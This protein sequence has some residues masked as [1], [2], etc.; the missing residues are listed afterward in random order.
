[1]EML[2]EEKNNEKEINTPDLDSKNSSL[3]RII[4]NNMY[5]PYIKALKNISNIYLDDFGNLCCSNNNGEKVII[6]NFVARPVLEMIKNNGLS[7]ERVVR[8]EGVLNGGRQLPPIDVSATEFLSMNWIAKRWGIQPQ[9]SSGINYRNLFKMAIQSMTYNVEQRKIF[10][11]LGWIKLENGRWTYLNASGCIGAE[12]ID[13]EIENSLENYSLPSYSNEKH[14]AVKTSLSLL[15]IAPKNITIPLLAFVYLTP[16][17]EAFRIVGIEPNFVVWLCGVTGTRKTSLAKVFLAHFGNFKSP[18]ATFKDTTSNLEKKAFLAKDSL[19]LIDDYHPTSNKY[20]SVEME[21]TAQ[22]ILRMYGDR[23]GRG[24]LTP[25]MEFQRDYPPRSNALITGEDLPKG[26]SSMARLLALELSNDQV[27]LKKLTYF[28]ENSHLLAESMVGYILWLSPKIDKL[29]QR[30]PDEFQRL[31]IK[32]QDVKMHGRLG[33]IAAWLHIAL[34][35]MLEYMKK[36][37]VISQKNAEEM[38]VEFESVIKNLIDNQAKLVAK[39]Q[40]SEIFTKVISE[41]IVSGKVCVRDLNLSCKNDITEHSNMDSIGWKDEKF[42]YLLPKTVYSI[43]NKFL[44]KQGEVIPVKERT[45]WK[46]LEEAGIICVET[47]GGGR[48][49][50]CVKKTIQCE[51]NKYRTRVLCVYRSAIDKE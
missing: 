8:I 21:K 28:Q 37:Q 3:P 35:L 1:M 4:D 41:L 30:L 17:L 7:E 34:I 26:Q 38:I 32:Y 13:V 48:V 9:I 23:I 25:N 43:I 24:R 11:H 39:E 16:L 6:S 31:R 29:T 49:H 14:L 46:H 33:E 51:S 45:L 10:T 12:N 50:R 42:Y 22:K 18:I 27:D 15:D 47:E 2:A 5:A 44:A 40:P 36:E 20:E 19:L